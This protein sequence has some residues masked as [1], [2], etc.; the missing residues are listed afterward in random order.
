MPLKP[1][2]QKIQTFLAKNNI[3]SEIIEFQ[4]STKTS[5][6][7]AN[8]IGCQLS[9]IAKSLIFQIKNSPELILIVASGSNQVDTKKVEKIIQA[10]ITRADINYIKQETGF[11]IGG[12]PPFAHSKEILTILDEDLKQYEEIYAAGG[13]PNT[14]FKL[15]P[16]QLQ[17]LTR[18]KFYEIKSSKNKNQTTLNHRRHNQQRHNNKNKKPQPL[19]QNLLNTSHFIPPTSNS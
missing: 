19:L 2:S 17:K 15:S 18:A 8:Q 3:N 4:E 12:I 14:I 7:A 5:L 9:Q 6:E 11:A 13:T 16:K 1:S 10:K